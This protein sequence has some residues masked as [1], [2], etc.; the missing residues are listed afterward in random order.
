MR[1]NYLIASAVE[2]R[3]LATKLAELGDDY[4][5]RAT[6]DDVAVVDREFLAKAIVIL[7]LTDVTVNDL[8]A[9]FDDIDELNVDRYT[10]A[11]NALYDDYAKA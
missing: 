3:E 7:G 11:A 10:L 1:K 8:L 2:Q 4:D 9:V 6:V 5:R